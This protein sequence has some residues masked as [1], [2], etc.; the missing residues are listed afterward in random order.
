ML[1]ASNAVDTTGKFRAYNHVSGI[2]YS[3]LDKIFDL[4]IVFGPSQSAGGWVK[5]KQEVVPKLGRTI[6]QHNQTQ[7]WD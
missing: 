7:S 2:G 3:Y 5:D 4:L 6:A 1:P